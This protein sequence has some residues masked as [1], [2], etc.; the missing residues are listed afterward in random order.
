MA[1]D[2]AVRALI[3]FGGQNETGNVSTLELNDTWEL[4]GNSSATLAWQPVNVSSA[5]LPCDSGSMLFDPELSTVLDF[6]GHSGAHAAA[7]FNTTY[8]LA[9]SLS[10]TIVANRTGGASPLSFNFSAEI[11][12]GLG[13]Y[14]Y[15]WN[16]GDK[17][18]STLAAPVHAYLR[19]GN[20]TVTL[21]VSD[22]LGA[23]A[24]TSLVVTPYHRL[25][26]D[27][28]ETVATVEPGQPVTWNVSTSGGLGTF[29]YAWTGLPSGCPALDQE[30]LTCSPRSA[31]N[32]TVGV[33]VTD[34]YNDS[35]TSEQNLTVQGSSTSPP[36]GNASKPSKFPAWIFAAGVVLVLSVILAIAL[37]RREQAQ[38]TA[39]P[40]PAPRSVPPGT[41]P[42]S[43]PPSS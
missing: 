29:R 5:P 22:S 8:A 39:P 6:G 10:V 3:L 1:F 21:N 18:T 24:R 35:A 42:R 15:A 28:N 30:I 14:Q 7:W 31:G 20:D 36:P 32:Y 13:P 23:E 34:P 33:N 17:S 27:L 11:L 9:L 2:P 41:P 25:R 43:P 19:R 12:G 37:W 38:K 16:F 26:A 4:V 40:R